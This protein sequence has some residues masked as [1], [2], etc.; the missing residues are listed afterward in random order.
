MLNRTTLR[1][2][3]QEAGLDQ[4]ITNILQT[5]EK[6]INTH[7]DLSELKRRVKDRELEVEDIE[8]S[9]LVESSTNGKNDTERKA[10]FKQ[11][12]AGDESWNRARKE[13]TDAQNH[14]DS[15]QAELDGLYARHS[16]Q[17]TV[18]NLIT[19]TLNASEE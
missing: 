10:I 15:L 7:R 16:A 6:I 19:A 9:H 13:A 4:L 14:R 5:T 18:A 11:L 12:C 2:L 8:M 17:K 3:R 1:T